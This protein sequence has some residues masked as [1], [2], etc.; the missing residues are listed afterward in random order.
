MELADEAVS[1]DFV[2]DLHVIEEGCDEATALFFRV[3]LV[4]CFLDKLR[5]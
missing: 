5:I 1:P 4:Q 3:E 2:E